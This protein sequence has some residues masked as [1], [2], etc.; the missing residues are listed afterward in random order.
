[1]RVFALKELSYSLVRS[2]WDIES[3][4]NYVKSVVALYYDARNE[5]KTSRNDENYDIVT[6]LYLFSDLVALM[7]KENSRE[8]IL[9][10]IEAVINRT[11]RSDETLKKNANRN[12]PALP[13]LKE[14][15]LEEKFV[16][17]SGA[18]GQKI[19]KTSNKV[20][21][22]H[23]PTRIRVECQETRS[24]QQ[25]RKIARKQMK[26]KLDDFFNGQNS[27]NNQKASVAA[28]KK[29]KT[30]ARNAR[31]QQQKKQKKE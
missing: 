20:I 31:R 10:E 12:T 13:E 24:L 17:G 30:K 8:V 15:E 23:I 25:N 6:F 14:S 4:N 27:R 9:K 21:L 22:V 5:R 28:A 1:M 2:E 19:N 18:G 11:I 29:A 26:L 16:K 3:V 7:P